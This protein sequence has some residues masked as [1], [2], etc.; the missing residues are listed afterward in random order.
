MHASEVWE[1][2]GLGP[3]LIRL[4]LIPFSFLYM[5]GWEAYLGV[6]R[7]GLKRAKHP[8][9]PILCV[10]N[11]VSGGSGKTPVV[12]C[13]VQSLLVRG[14]K[15]VVSCSGYGSPRSEA[16]S[17]APEGPLAA[18]EWGDEAALF[19]W[20][21]PDLPL[22]VGRRRVLAA[23]LCHLTFPEHVLLMDDGF[24]HLPL[25]KDLTIILDPPK[26][27]NPF[28]LPAGPY[29]EGPWNRKRSDL[30][31]PGK[32]QIEESCQVL[33]SPEGNLVSIPPKIALICAVGQPRNVI[34]AIEL[35]GCKIVY[36]DLRPDHDALTGG[37]L[38]SSLPKD[39]PTVVTG[40]DWVKLKDR[41]DVAEREFLI[42]DHQV[43]I[44]PE[45][46]F[47]I[48]LQEGLD[49]IQQEANHSR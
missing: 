13:L 49:V 41:S 42:L 34:R 3:T 45:K 1:G 40:K 30:V 14:A 8:H 21:F 2:R 37:T 39:V 12:M 16:A 5:L 29:R 44:T 17:I 24:Q 26:P 23:E 11:L 22:I 48:W 28:C 18:S 10:G 46:E 36:Q 9:S 33:M 47:S 7:L 27:I 38:I 43:K 31:I 15:V 19:R 35:L 32:F 6:Y 4:A 20:R 25:K